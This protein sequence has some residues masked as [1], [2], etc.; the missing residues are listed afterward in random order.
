M[1]AASLS[2]L[3]TALLSL[4]GCA[5]ERPGTY[6]GFLDVPVAAVAVQVSGLLAAVAVREGDRV[7]RGQLLARLDARERA[8]MVSQ[9]EANVERAAQALRE[10]QRNTEA[11]VPTVRGAEADI[12][13]ANADLEDA[14]TSFERTQRLFA[15]GAATA[16]QLDSARPAAVA[17]APP[18]RRRRRRR[19]RCTAPRR[20]ST[21]RGSSSS[22]PRCTAPSRGWWSSRTC[23]PA[24]GPPP[25]RR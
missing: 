2:R 24:S 12:A 11:V 25:A 19:R 23:R 21:W 17:S 20:H 10:A 6:A 4:A 3:A 15:S 14:R 22:R 18:S 16:A 5:R 13:R 7:H 8:T 1:N 9:A